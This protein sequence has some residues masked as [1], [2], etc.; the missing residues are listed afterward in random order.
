MLS[1]SFF[2]GN[3]KTLFNLFFNNEYDFILKGLEKQTSKFILYLNLLISNLLMI[4]VSIEN[5]KEKK[6]FDEF[7]FYIKENSKIKFDQGNN[8]KKINELYL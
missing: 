8:F 2:K 3:F 7:V 1:E 6:T 5:D 4:S